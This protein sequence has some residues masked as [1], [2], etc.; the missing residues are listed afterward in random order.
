MRNSF[1]R[2]SHGKFDVFQSTGWTVAPLRSKS[3]PSPQELTF[4]GFDQAHA[5]GAEP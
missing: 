4:E 5:K 2:A 1:V 3:G